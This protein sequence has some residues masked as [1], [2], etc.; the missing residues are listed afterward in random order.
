M[1]E[2]GNIADA[3][4]MDVMGTSVVGIGVTEDRPIP[5][6]AEPPG[7]AIG[8]SPLQPEL[9]KLLIIEEYVALRN[10]IQKRIEIRQQI[11]YLT[12]LVA[13]TFLT[14][15]VQTT[16][17]RS[18]ALIYPILAFFLAVGWQQQDLRIGQISYYIR[19]ELEQHM[20]P[21]GIGWE[22]FRKR[23]F[24]RPEKPETRQKRPRAN[25]REEQE[26]R[27]NPQPGLTQLFS[28]GVFVITQL[29]AIGVV[30]V[31]YIDMPDNLATFFNFNN[32]ANL[33]ITLI[34]PILLAI[35]LLCIILTVSYVRHYRR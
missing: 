22:H 9:A 24:G 21:Y 32:T 3:F 7:T 2:S 12:L 27:L 19:R 29:L 33:G 34:D 13:G 30:V 10:E 17:P 16:V 1:E 11:V 23:H 15:G 5:P 14:V 6:G 28:R 26:H 8:P 31:R 25:A 18:L 4:A 20:E 35:D